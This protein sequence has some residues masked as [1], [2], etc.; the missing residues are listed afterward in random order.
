VIETHYNK[1]LEFLNME[2]E[3]SFKEFDTYYKQVLTELTD[4][5]NF[6]QEQALHALFIMDNLKS[7]SDS[8][9]ER[10]FAE[11]KKYKKISERCKVWVE[12]L[13]IELKKSGLTE[14][15]ITDKIEAMY[16]TA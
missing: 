15:E 12:A 11:A 16:E 7:N 14:K 13:F 3:I 1:M 6:N 2:E 4:Y 8:R 5:Q 10:R 9:I